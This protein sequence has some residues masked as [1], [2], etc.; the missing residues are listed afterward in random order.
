MVGK[1][2]NKEPE[3]RDEG[4]LFLKILGG[5]DP[6]LKI[7][8]FL[9]DNLAFDYSKTDI[10]AG[11]GI[12]RTTLFSVW[13]NLEANELV[14]FTREVGRAKMYKLNMENQ[15]VKKL[16][17][18]DRAISSYHASKLDDRAVVIEEVSENRSSTPICL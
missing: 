9:I 11:A 6:T 4:S 13:D 2:A 16:I 14:A 10:A 3:N 5:K 12:S 1:M 18:L 7:L 8:D 15:V 17:E